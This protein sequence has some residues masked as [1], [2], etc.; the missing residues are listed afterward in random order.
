LEDARWVAAREL[1]DG[2]RSGEYSL[3]APISIS[4]RLIREWLVR[5]CGEAATAA[6][7]ARRD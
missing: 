4:H 3:P 7:L 5:Q 2:L 1:I 6:A